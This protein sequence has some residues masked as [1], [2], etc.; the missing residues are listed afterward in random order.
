[1]CRMALYLGPEITLGSLL[2]EPDHSIVKQSVEA[3]EREEPLNGD[4]FGVAWYDPELEQPALFK[5]VR[6]AWSNRNLI[7]LGRVVRTSA[8]MAHVRAATPPL[9]VH[10]LNCHPF[11]WGRLSFMHNGAIGGFTQLKRALQAKL[12]DE[13]YRWI[14]GS[15]DSEHLFALAIDEYQRHEPGTLAALEASLLAAIRQAEELREAAGIESPSW[16][17]LVI[18]DGERAVAT[19]AIFGN[20]EGVKPESLYYHVGRRYVCEEGVCRMVPVEDAGAVLVASEPLSADPGW[21][22]V[23]AGHLIAIAADRSLEVRPLAL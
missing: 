15:T 4:G 14:Q 18:C 7:E 3:R 22:E 23:P 12:S 17:N 1:M 16:F 21:Q 6:P 13:A 2:T 5:D 9:P 8:L 20:R 19:R 11:R 10:E